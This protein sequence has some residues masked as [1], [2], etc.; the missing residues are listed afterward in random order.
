[1]YKAIS[2]NLRGKYWPPLAGMHS[3]HFNCYVIL[4]L[5][6][7]I[8]DI[9][10]L[11]FLKWSVKLAFVRL[12][13]YSFNTTRNDQQEPR[14]GWAGLAGCVLKADRISWQVVACC[15]ALARVEIRTWTSFILAW[16]YLLQYCGV[17]CPCQ[18][19]VT[20]KCLVITVQ[21]EMQ[22]LHATLVPTLHITVRAYQNSFLFI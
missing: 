3:L 9:Y 20:L 6:I 18:Q 22:H 17:W 5:L 8:R 7:F 16:L 21:I 15:P 4:F 2:G 1:M 14:L 13:I 10:L 12:E 19:G 11:S